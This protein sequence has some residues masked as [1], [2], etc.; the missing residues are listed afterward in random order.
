M[1]ARIKSI[2]RSAIVLRRIDV[3]IH[4][5]KIHFFQ[6]HVVRK[7]KK[8]NFEFHFFLCSNAECSILVLCMYS[9]YISTVIVYFPLSTRN[10][11]SNEKCR[12]YHQ[13][14]TH[15]SEFTI[16]YARVQ[17]R[18]KYKAFVMYLQHKGHI[19]ILFSCMYNY[20]VI[21]S[22]LDKLNRIYC[23]LNFMQQCDSLKIALERPLY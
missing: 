7:G 13:K 12:I 16:H 6:G 11:T 22:M 1:L 8:V 5:F 20:L 14:L 3:S 23:N 21:A 15:N 18:K 19:R 2:V 9:L 10:M 17:K 4:L